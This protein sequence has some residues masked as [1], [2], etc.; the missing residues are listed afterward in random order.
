M[1]GS[2][3]LGCIVTVLGYLQTSW[4]RLN[5][6]IHYCSS[7]LYNY[8]LQVLPIPSVPSG[9]SF[10]AFMV[11]STWVHAWISHTTC[12]TTGIPCCYISKRSQ[13]HKHFNAAAA[14]AKER[15]LRGSHWKFPSS[16]TYNLEKKKK[17]D[18]RVEAPGYTHDMNRICTP[19]YNLV[20]FACSSRW[21]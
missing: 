18:M 19:T 12:A 20:K 6:T 11:M 16:P 7:S 2:E 21:D 10:A 1:Q 14:Q 15:R 9:P 4:L 17:V 3:C 8:K 13:I 5:L